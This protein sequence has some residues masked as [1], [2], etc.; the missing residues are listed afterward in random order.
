MSERMDITEYIP[1]RL[2][3]LQQRHADLKLELLRVEAAIGELLNMTQPAQPE[4][5]VRKAR[6]ASG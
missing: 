1:A 2:T 4:K 6:K 3:F 5:P